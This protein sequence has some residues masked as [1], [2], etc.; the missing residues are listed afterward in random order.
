MIVKM[1][2]I[3]ILI[4]K[5]LLLICRNVIDFCMFILYPAS[6]WNSLILSRSFIG[7]FLEI[8]YINV[9]INFK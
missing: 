8:F 2:Y 4:S 5:C 6:L 7:I 3:L 9:H 1:Y